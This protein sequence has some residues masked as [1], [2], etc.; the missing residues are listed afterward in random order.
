MLKQNISFKF[1]DKKYVT[2]ENFTQQKIKNLFTK[3]DE[4]LLISDKYVQMLHE[5]HV[6]LLHL[7][8]K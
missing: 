1:R 6:V 3:L 8:K 4:N 5:F 7:E 2:V